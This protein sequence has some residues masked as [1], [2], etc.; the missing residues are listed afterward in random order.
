MTAHNY[1]K[2]KLLLIGLQLASLHS[3]RENHCQ[4]FDIS[5]KKPGC[6][7]YVVSSGNQEISKVAFVAATHC[8]QL[9]IYQQVPDSTFIVSHVSSVKDGNVVIRLIV[10]D[11]SATRLL[12][13]CYPSGSDTINHDLRKLK[14]TVIDGKKVQVVE[15][16]DNQLN[17]LADDIRKMV[18]VSEKKYVMA[19]RDFGGSL[20]VLAF[21]QWRDE[22]TSNRESR[23]MTFSAQKVGDAAFYNLFEAKIPRNHERKSQSRYLRFE[24]C[25]TKTIKFQSAG[26][27]VILGTEK[28]GSNS[29]MTYFDKSCYQ[30][31]AIKKL[32]KA[33]RWTKVNRLGWTLPAD[34]KVADGA[35]IEA[36]R[37]Y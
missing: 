16:A 27:T 7:K 13:F 32:C 6:R 14:S 29:G 34:G 25:G 18:S 9:K 19:G 37:N 20:A 28:K 8:E 24:F 15:S 4:H 30:K 12:I 1:T 22:V 33:E 21:L 3:E 5:R 2:F 23:L 31:D 17:L 36:L 26:T 11:D 10:A 35:Y